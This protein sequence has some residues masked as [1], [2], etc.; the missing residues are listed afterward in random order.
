MA[1]LIVIVVLLFFAAIAYAYIYQAGHKRGK[2]EGSRK[3]YGVGYS[4]GRRHRGKSNGPCFVATA[5]FAN[6]RHPAVIILRA[7]RDQLLCRCASGRAFIILYA[8]TGPALARFVQG[9]EELRRWVRRQLMIIAWRVR[10]KV[11]LDNKHL[12][13]DRALKR[14]SPRKSS[15]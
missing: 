15:R 14:N 9:R 13:H 6:D 11:N 10:H 1:T 12:V 5:A 8:Y 7:V 2:R 4:R 3:G